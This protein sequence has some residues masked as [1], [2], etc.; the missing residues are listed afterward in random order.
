MKIVI[1]QLSLVLLLFSAPA[2]F[3]AV[4]V[5]VDESLTFKNISRDVDYIE[6]TK[7]TLT[8]DDVRNNGTLR[9]KQ[10]RTRSINFGF[11]RSQYWFRFTVDNLSRSAVT[12]LLE[13][14]FPCLDL[15]ELYAPDGRGQYL[16][17]KTGDS[18]PFSSRDIPFINYLFRMF[19]DTGPVT[20]YLRID[21]L[22]SINININM[23]S[24]MF[25]MERYTN[26]M[27]LYWLFFGIMA[28]MA[29]Y[30]IF[31]FIP[32]RDR[33][34]IYLALAVITFA[35]F[36]FNFKG[37]GS[38]YLWHDAG[39]WTDRANPFLVSLTCVWVDLFVLE[40]VGVRKHSPRLYRFSLVT[41]TLPG[42]VLTV[43]SLLTDLQVII[44]TVISFT[45]YVIVMIIA[46]GVYLL[47]VKNPA[48]RQ[49]LITLIAFSMIVITMPFVALTM[50]GMIL[51]NFYTRWA[52]QFGSSA[53]VLLLSFGMAVKIN[54]M[55]N[56]IKKAERKYRHLVESTSDIIFTLDEE[57]RILTMNGAV[58]MHLGFK[59]E[60][61]VETNFID[62]I[63]EHLNKKNDVAQQMALECINDLKKKKTGSAQFRT[64]MKDKYSHEPR[65]LTVSLEYNRDDRAG[66]AILGKASPVIDDTLTQFIVGEEYTYDLNNYLGNAELM[67]QRLVRNLNKFVDP[68]TVSDVRIALREAIINAIEHG[69][70]QMTFDVKTEAYRAGSYFDLIRERQ[71]DPVLNQKTVRVTCSLNDERVSY[72]ISDEGHGFDIASMEGL[73]PDDINAASLTHGRGLHMIRSAFDTIH[74]NEKGNQLLLVKYFGRVR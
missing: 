67:S 64:T 22:D 31:I 59:P 36:E 61:L 24:E 39:W 63:Q 45:V 15:V 55:K 13:V 30:N 54:M 62:L 21:S 53:A 43:L 69:N 51:P 4:H 19:Q 74:F 9:W 56:R 33:E 16:S 57:N 7:K 32:T 49:A 37:F 68:L 65:E 29:L 41:I 11:T 2:G 20:Y 23:L 44:V 71:M 42:L 28:V 72:V 17:R 47:I 18:Q 40:F 60:E 12:W 1:S 73:S 46:K 3:A 66:Y 5:S 35:L 58:R 50:L 14:D 6:D 25:F 52:L 10:V 48:M 38:Q 27:P 8:F 70:L 26:D 34:H